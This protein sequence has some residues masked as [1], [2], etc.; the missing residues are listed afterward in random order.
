MYGD[1][2]SAPWTRGNLRIP[3]SVL[4][5][6]ENAA[7]EAYAKDE[8][9][10]GYLEGP[11]EEGTRIDRAVVME[12]LAN[13]YHAVD[14]VGHPRT[15]REYFKIHT[16]KFE[17]A[18]AQAKLDDR[19]VKVFFHSHLDCGA[20]FS[21]EDAASMTMGDGAGPT[22]ELAYLVTA[23]DLGLVSKHRLFIWDETSRSFVESPFSVES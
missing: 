7:R 5:V 6:V 12:N 10:C 18:L 15:G 3:K 1:A 9:S 22:Y 14:P 4:E 21:K 20:Y 16:L 23:V 13:K 2:M 19:A 17:R 8:E 11:L